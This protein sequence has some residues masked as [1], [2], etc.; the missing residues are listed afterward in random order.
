VYSPVAGEVTEINEDLEDDPSVVNS[1]P[2]GAGWFIKLKVREEW[3]AR[4]VGGERGG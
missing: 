1:E 2:F 4:G 3:G